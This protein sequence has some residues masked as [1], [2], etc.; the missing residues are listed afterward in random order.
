MDL[1]IVI[2][3]L[4]HAWMILNKN[5][6]LINLYYFISLKLFRNVDL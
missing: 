1:S 3:R 6:K 4:M 5:I 2:D